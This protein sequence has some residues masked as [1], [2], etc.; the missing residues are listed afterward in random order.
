M[1]GLWQAHQLRP[2]EAI[3]RRNLIWRPRAGSRVQYHQPFANT[4]GPL[5]L[6][7]VT[8]RERVFQRIA[9]TDDR[10]TD[11]D[12]YPVYA[13][14][15]T[16]VLATP[17]GFEGAYNTSPSQISLSPQKVWETDTACG[18]PVGAWATTSQGQGSRAAYA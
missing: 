15:L 16:V 3:P 7:A 1:G 4:F 14:A 18:R 5:A 2:R 17:S 10:L 12:V 6:G 9:V 11:V 13:E 8:S